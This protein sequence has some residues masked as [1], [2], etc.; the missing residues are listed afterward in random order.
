MLWNSHCLNTINPDFSLVME[1]WFK[2]LEIHLSK[3]VR[4]LVRA[5]V[6]MSY[7]QVVKGHL[8]MQVSNKIQR[9]L[10]AQYIYIYMSVT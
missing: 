4:T 1:I 7:V 3:C 8:F 10:N 5:G 2:V 9:H 6:S